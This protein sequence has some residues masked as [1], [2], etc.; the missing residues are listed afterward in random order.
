MPLT[1]SSI[2]RP[3]KSPSCRPSGAPG[4]GKHGGS[5][6]GGVQGSRTELRE[7]PQMVQLYPNAWCSHLQS[8]RL[9]AEEEGFLVGVHE[10]ASWQSVCGVHQVW[11]LGHNGGPSPGTSWSQQG[12]RVEI[13]LFWPTRSGSLACARLESACEANAGECVATYRVTGTAGEPARTYFG[14]SRT[15][16]VSCSNIPPCCQLYRP[17][18]R[19]AGP[20]R[21]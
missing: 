10:G 16:A 18:P 17:P 15:P 19:R 3:H 2:L 14:K 8:N 7:C 1:G 11:P 12:S 6:W 9:G 20:R 5:G 13:A 4:P 21:R